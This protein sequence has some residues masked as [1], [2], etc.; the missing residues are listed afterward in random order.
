MRKLVVFNNVTVDGYF[1]GST[2]L[3]AGRKGISR[4]QD[5]FKRRAAAINVAM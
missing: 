3:S 5:V 4:T 1:A 2:A